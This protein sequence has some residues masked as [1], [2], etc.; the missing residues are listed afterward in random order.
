MVASEIM[1]RS[2]T[3]QTRPMPKRPRRRSTTGSSTL[4]SAVL[5]GHISV[6]TGRPSA[7][8]TRQRIICIRSGL[9]SLE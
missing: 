3:T 9:W 5:P 4:T 7:S 1:P 2:A 8:I 6:Q